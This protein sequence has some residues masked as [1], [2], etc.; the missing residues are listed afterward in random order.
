MGEL[1][2]MQDTT[3]NNIANGQHHI[4]FLVVGFSGI[5][6]LACNGVVDYPGPSDPVPGGGG[7]SSAPAGDGGPVPAR[8][9]TAPVAGTAAVDECA[10]VETSALAVL[11]TH[12]AA[13]HGPGTNTAGFDY[14]LDAK[15]L[16]T[17]GKIVRGNALSSPLY[18]R[19]A[20]DDMPPAAQKQRPTDE[21]VAV[22]FKWIDGCLADAPQGG[23]MAGGGGG[24][25]FDTQ[26]MLGWM[27]ADLNTFDLDDRKSIRYL[28]LTHLHNVGITGKDLD[29]FRY[30]LAKAVNALSQGTQIVSPKAIDQNS[31]VFRIDLRD[32]EWDETS[33]RADKWEELVAAN[34]YA[35][36]LLEDEAEVLKFFTETDVPFQAGDW[37]INAA[38]QPPLY[39]TMLD[40]PATR[41][42]LEGQL[43]LDLVKNIEDE[44]VW[45]AGFLN[46]GISFQ[47]RVI[48]RHE[49]PV[50]NSRSL[51]ISYDFAGNGGLENIFANPLDFQP[52]G[53]EIIFSL[54][55]GLHAYM[56]V[57]AAG[58]RLNEAPD[59]IVVDPQQQDRD[60]RN[61][62]SCMSC[63]SAGTKVKDD[64]LRSYVQG[65]ADFNFDTKQRIAA[66]HPDAADFQ[67][68][69]DKD[70]EVFLS[71]V[72]SLNPPPDMAGE[73]IITVFNE[74]DENVNLKRAAA[75]L[76]V[77][78]ETLL[79]ELGGLNPEL[80]PLAYTSI[81]RDVF[82]EAFAETVCRLN[83]G[84]TNDPACAGADDDTVDDRFGQP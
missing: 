84:L 74:F 53:S 19:M 83:I 57:D 30:A 5:V 17:S 56:I 47:N 39:H 1:L 62:I 22:I 48:E 14:V 35:I 50:A 55:N 46:S 29:V 31:T 10:N 36:E 59:N 32:Y 70:A 24:S 9:G 54:P 2:P 15:A 73:P 60:V 26:T 49:I 44:E 21:D 18:K 12:C 76:G 77:R 68:L 79:A 37:F 40:I 64:E 71:A 52:D 51:W 66:L 28:S 13:C 82:R 45:R 58:N 3:M 41:A 8:A 42:G 6:T 27:I 16:E 33:T 25:Y 11:E 81:K 69:L 63:H 61:G 4:S 78:P 23:G 75:E 67:S 20:N 72:D 43:G 34:P 7:T 65:S 38:T 80:A